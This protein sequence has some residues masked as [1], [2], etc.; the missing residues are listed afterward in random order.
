LGGDGVTDSNSSAI[1]LVVCEERTSKSAETKHGQSSALFL[2]K[3]YVQPTRADR[4]AVDRDKINQEKSIML[5]LSSQ[6]SALQ[7]K[8]GLRQ[9]TLTTDPL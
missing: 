4:D 7:E 9:G 3:G 2:I 6:P 5:I 8:G 1:I